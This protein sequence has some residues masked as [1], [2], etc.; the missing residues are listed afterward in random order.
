MFAGANSIEVPRERSSYFRES[1]PTLAR[2]NSTRT[3]ILATPLSFL[4][5]SPNVRCI[6]CFPG[7]LS[8][9][10]TE[11]CNNGIP[12]KE[13]LEGE[14]CCHVQCP[15]CG[16]SGCATMTGGS[17]LDGESCCVSAIKSS[18]MACSATNEAPCYMECEYPTHPA[19]PPPP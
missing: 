10:A 5:A 2:R 8:N 16:G 7:Y 14:V 19:R 1:S 12:G 9:R 4:S 15:Q 18:G 6:S 3:G 17:D 11:T 13:S